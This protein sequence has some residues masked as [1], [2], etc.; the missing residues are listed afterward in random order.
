MGR[1]QKYTTKLAKDKSPGLNGVP[2]NALK[3]LDDEN[4]TW[5]LLLYNQF[6]R[7]KSDFY[8]WNEGWRERTYQGRPDS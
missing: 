7:R 6:W 2:P 1:D 5:L 8:E 4:I 3:A